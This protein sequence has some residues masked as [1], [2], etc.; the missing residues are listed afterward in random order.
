MEDFVRNQLSDHTD[1]QARARHR[2][3]LDNLAEQLVRD[4]GVEGAKRICREYCWDGVSRAID[5]ANA[6]PAR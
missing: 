5:I 3:S 4:Y 2:R 6:A 1:N